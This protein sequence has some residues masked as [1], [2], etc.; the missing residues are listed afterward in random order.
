[1]RALQVALA[2]PTQLDKLCCCSLACRVRAWAY[3]GPL[4]AASIGGGAVGVVMLSTGTHIWNNIAITGMIV[5]FTV[6]VV[7]TE[8][9]QQM[10]FAV[11][12]V[13]QASPGIL[14]AQD[15]IGGELGAPL[16]SVSEM[17]S[18]SP[19]FGQEPQQA[20]PEHLQ[21]PNFAFM[22]RLLRSRVS[23][24][25]AAK[26]KRSVKVVIVQCTIYALLVEFCL[27][28]LAFGV[29]G[30]YGT[31]LLC[32]SIS[33]LIC[34]AVGCGFMLFF[35]VPCEVAADRIRQQAIRVRGMTAADA[36]WNSIM[37][38]V[39]QAHETT[40]RL[41]ALLSPPL[42]AFHLVGALAGSWWFVCGI[43]PRDNVPEDHI[44]RTI[45]IPPA[46]LAAV[47]MIQA[48]AVGF[49]LFFCDFQEEKAEIT[50]FFVHFTE[51]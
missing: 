14:G 10:A 48:A 29:E 3:M 7:M 8:S 35:K 23:P 34:G 31:L 12:G 21:N 46:F 19:R 42:T 40:V 15:K 27:V 36:D 18:D 26:V 4:A 45:F 2:G 51:K 11:V 6:G 9:T 41:G 16:S 30:M 39:Q 43:A 33:A 47:I 22:E 49:F 13:L 50:P 1:M 5:W 28:G 20:A 17:E 24:R 44:L 38:A 37:G 32:A 25:V